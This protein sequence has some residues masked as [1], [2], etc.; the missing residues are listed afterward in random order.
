M[1]IINKGINIQKVYN[2]DLKGFKII[3][4]SIKA[5]Y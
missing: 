3:F 4:I 5:L 1:Q 2:K